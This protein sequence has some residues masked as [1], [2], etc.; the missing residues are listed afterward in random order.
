MTIFNIISLVQ[1]ITTLMS[2]GGYKTKNPFK[3]D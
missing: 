1:N 2:M 3:V